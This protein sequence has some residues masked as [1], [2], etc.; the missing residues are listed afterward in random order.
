MARTILEIQEAIDT[1][2]AANPDLVSKLT[3]T[4]NAS[5]W[6]LIRNVV[7]A[8]IYSLEQIFDQHKAEVQAIANLSEYGLP[9][10]YKQKALAFQY[11]D[12][13]AIV[14]GVPVYPLIDSTKLIVKRVSVN[15]GPT[16]GLVIKLAKESSGELVALSNAELSSFKY[17]L[18]KIKFAGI[19]TAIISMAGDMIKG[20]VTVYHD[21][22]RE[23]LALQ[24]DLNSAVA[25]FLGNIEFDGRF[26][27]IRLIDALQVVDGV[28]DVKINNLLWKPFGGI[29]TAIDRYVDPQS[30]YFKIDTAGGGI[31]WTL[32]AE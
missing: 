14:N 21:G 11:G 19:Y 18:N 17:Y 10:W 6:R 26:N 3:S 5:I 25:S 9:E 7:A 4:S 22:L 16:G 12:T 24:N 29:Y 23:D 20:A 32:T 1:A 2:K 13:L 31:T 30:G 27:M 15:D 8:V 28:T